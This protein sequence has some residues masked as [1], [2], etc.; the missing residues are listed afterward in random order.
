[1]DEVFAGKKIRCK[2]C[3]EPFRVNVPARP[4]SSATPLPKPAWL[5][6]FLQKNRLSAVFA[7][8]IGAGLLLIGGVLLVIC[9]LTPGPI[10]QQ[11]QNLK[12]RNPQVSA[13]A[14]EWLVEA[15]VQDSER[16]RV[17]GAL[18][19]LLIDGDVHGNLDPDLLLR[20]YLAWA[21]KDNVPALVRMVENPTLPA[22]NARKTGLV[23]EAL[24]KT[25]D[26][27]AASA[28]AEKLPDP[29][30]HDQ[31]VNGLKVLGP[32]AQPLVLGYLFDP[33]PAT[34]DRAR[35]LLDDYGTK[36]STIAAEA[37]KALTSRNVDVRTSAVVWFVDNQPGDESSQAAAADAIALQLSNPKIRGKAVKGLLKLGPVA[38]KAVLRHLNDP[39]PQVHKDVRD[40][41]RR[42]NLPANAQLRQTLADAAGSDLPRAVAALQYLARLRPEEADRAQVASALNAALV[43]P[44][45]GI[46]QAALNAVAVWGATDNT[47]TL[48]KLLGDFPGVDGAQ[49]AAIIATLAKIKDPR[50]APV[51]ARGLTDDRERGLVGQALIAMGPGAEEA[52]LPFLQSPDRGARVE[53]SLILAEIGTSKSVKPLQEALNQY[54]WGDGFFVQ[55]AQTAM[56]K[57]AARQ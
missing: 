7:L 52:V 28:L 47:A 21:G 30:L 45:P 56:Q 12:S 51:L 22:W 10:D 48:V 29:V 27:R 24:A 25:G 32:R 38:S 23:M 54:G 37:L 17:T 6:A 8:A 41:A 57:I 14:L 43:D 49:H 13:A 16:A 42:L 44:N 33:D 39:D 3:N 5:P 31:A 50:A 35:R 36:P 34:R 26:D 40:L 15:E 9:L 19:P 11:L 2:Q 4:A 1:L 55:Q 53:A 20:V 18:E 46:H